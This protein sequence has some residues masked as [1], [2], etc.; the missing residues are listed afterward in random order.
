MNN[1]QAK[2]LSNLANKIKSE[3]KDRTRIVVS[4]TTAKILTKNGNI[5]NHYSNLK[6]VVAIAK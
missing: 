4:L 2:L 6:K 1:N 3:P 5:T